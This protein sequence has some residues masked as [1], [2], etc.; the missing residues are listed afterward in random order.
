MEGPIA[1]A[2]RTSTHAIEAIC[3]MVQ[4]PGGVCFR[5]LLETTMRYYID[6]Y[7]QTQPPNPLK[8]VPA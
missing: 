1:A 2:T 7:R 4:N 6:Q 8:V 5:E 3:R